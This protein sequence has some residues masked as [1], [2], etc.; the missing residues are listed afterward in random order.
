MRVLPL[1]PVATGDFQLEFLCHLREKTHF[2]LEIHSSQQCLLP[3]PLTS[4]DTDFVRRLLASLQ[5]MHSGHPISCWGFRQ[6]Q[7]NSD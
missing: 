2:L 3:V 4:A 1:E 5:E 7:A 6:L